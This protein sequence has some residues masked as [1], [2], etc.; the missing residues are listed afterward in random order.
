[1]I[2]GQKKC[3]PFLF[4]PSFRMNPVRC[5]CLTYLV[6]VSWQLLESKYNSLLSPDLPFSCLH[7]YLGSVPLF[8]WERTS[9]LQRGFSDVRPMPHL[10]TFTEEQ[11]NPF[12]LETLQNDDINSVPSLFSL[13]LPFFVLWPRH[14]AFSS[15]EGQTRNLLEESS[16]HPTGAEVAVSL[17]QGAP[18]LIQ[19]FQTPGSIQE[20]V[21]KE[22]STAWG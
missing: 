21:K 8:L 18:P 17:P 15:L 3:K 10:S 20:S 6:K 22:L 11:G 5:S 2:C 13:L 16:C 19:L 12:S 9:Y 7:R 14:A 4:T 1:M